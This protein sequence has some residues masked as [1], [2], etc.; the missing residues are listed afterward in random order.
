MLTCLAASAARQVGK[1]VLNILFF[2][3]QGKQKD[4]I[5]Q[6]LVLRDCNY[7]GTKLPATLAQG[8]YVTW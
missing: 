6:N 5:K 7:G 1:V 2:D 4:D 3:E 8:D